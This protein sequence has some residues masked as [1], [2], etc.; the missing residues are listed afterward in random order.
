MLNGGYSYP[1]FALHLICTQRKQTPD[2]RCHCQCSKLIGPWCIFYSLPI[3]IPVP[4]MA[5]CS[6]G[7]DQTNPFCCQHVCN[8]SQLI[9]YVCYIIIM[10]VRG[11]PTAGVLFTCHWVI[12]SRQWE[13]NHKHNREQPINTD[14]LRKKKSVAVQWPNREIPGPKTPRTDSI[15]PKHP[16]AHAL[17]LKKIDSWMRWYCLI[18]S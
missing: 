11:T 14:S 12:I 6:S 2:G 16:L 10:L 7:L 8:W 3:S 17:L 18:C 15:L 1:F 9:L 4:V 5:S 13:Q